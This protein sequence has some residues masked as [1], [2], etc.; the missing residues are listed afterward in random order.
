MKGGCQRRHRHGFACR[1]GESLHRGIAAG[2]GRSQKACL[3]KRQLLPQPGLATIIGLEPC[4]R[5]CEACLLAIRPQARIDGEKPALAGGAAKPACECLREPVEIG[6]RAE[7]PPAIRGAGR[8]GVG[9]RIPYKHKVEVGG[10]RQLAKPEP[11]HGDHGKVAGN[12]AV[13]A[14]HVVHCKVADNPNGGLG[15]VRQRRAKPLPVRNAAEPL[16]LG[17]E[18]ALAGD[19]RHHVECQFNGLV[20][21]SGAKLAFEIIGWCEWLE[22]FAKQHKVEQH[23]ML[24]QPVGKPWRKN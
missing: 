17:P 7:G 6:G 19:A 2:R 16:H 23:R 8:D 13:A 21:N 18:L 10:R 20:F 15:G 12:A 3:A 4:Q 22:E 5:G 11:A 14:F 1:P 24:P 9:R